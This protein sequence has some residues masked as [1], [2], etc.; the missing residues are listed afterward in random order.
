LFRRIQTTFSRV[1]ET[2]RPRIALFIVRR[3]IT[4]SIAEKVDKKIKN[5]RKFEINLIRW[6]GNSRIARNIRAGDI[7]VQIQN[8]GK[9]KEEVNPPSRV[10]HFKKYHSFDNAKNPRIL[11]YIEE[12]KYFSPI[13]W[14]DFKEQ[15]SK[16]GL[17]RISKNSCR[18]INSGEARFQILKL[19]A[20]PS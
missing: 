9:G 17:K 3:I 19:W 14:R 4:E 8:E 11:I 12:P 2:G 15:L 10:V 13:Q 7:I 20:A 6:N 5:K 18:M 16:L 1:Q